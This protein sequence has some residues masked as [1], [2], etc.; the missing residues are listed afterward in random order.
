M[1][2]CQTG[3]GSHERI[4][5]DTKIGKMLVYDAALYQGFKGYCTGQDDISLALKNT[6]I[7]EKHETETVTDVLVRG[8]PKFNAMIDI[9]SHI[10]WYSILAA[11]LGYSV[12]AIEADKE[13]IEL[14]KTNAAIHN[15]TR[16]I[17][18]H[19]FWVGGGEQCPIY[20]DAFHDEFEV[21]LVKID[22][23][24][25]EQ[26]AVSMLE[27][28]LSAKKTRHIFMEVSPVFN[29]SYPKLVQK[30][31]DYGFRAFIHGKPFDGSFD[32]DQEN[33]LFV[34]SDLA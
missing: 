21:E 31:I 11:K 16:H 3:H 9:G 26:H 12:F 23:E 5:V 6:G 27:P 2:S 30:I 22:I 10:G 32:F 7:W 19:H 1:N 28:L 25:N 18:A 34:R 33:F 29:K 17:E 15:Q 24:G 14:L 20:L 4:I 8:N 13:N